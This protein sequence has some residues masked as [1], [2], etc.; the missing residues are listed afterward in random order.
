VKQA[1]FGKV[2]KPA[3]AEKVEWVEADKLWTYMAK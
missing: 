1:V 3:P 2:L